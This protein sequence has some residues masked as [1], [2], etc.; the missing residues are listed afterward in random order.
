MN[1]F[2]NAVIGNQKSATAARRY[3][4]YALI[5]TV[6][7]FVLAVVVLI[8]SSIAFS[9]SD[10]D[11]SAAGAEDAGGEGGA[12]T[13]VGAIAYEVIGSEAMDARK[14]D[15]VVLADIR[16]KLNTGS[17]HHYYKLGAHFKH[18]K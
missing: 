13:G 8:A 14:G 18:P 10:G 7:A 6:V 12:A 17:S 16:T 2:L 1:K 3:V 5:G 15:I 9:V 11:A 4:T